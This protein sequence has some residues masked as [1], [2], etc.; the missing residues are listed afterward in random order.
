MNFQT[1]GNTG[2]GMTAS[3]KTEDFFFAPCQLD[4][5]AF[6]AFGTSQNNTFCATASKRFLGA[7]R[8]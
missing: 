1:A 2:F 8:D 7:L 4:T 5:G 6:S 3:E